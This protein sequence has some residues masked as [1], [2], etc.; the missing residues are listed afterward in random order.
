MASLLGRA[1]M[2][3]FESLSVFMFGS[4]VVQRS[5]RGGNVSFQDETLAIP[6]E[7]AVATMA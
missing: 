5:G 1:V 3:L 6:A 4:T 2:Q 7:A